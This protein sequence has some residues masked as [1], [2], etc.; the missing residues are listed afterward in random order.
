MKKQH[1]IYADVET[2][3]GEVITALVPEYLRS[4][5]L[6]E[7]SVVI[8]R[9][10]RFQLATVVSTSIVRKHTVRATVCDRWKRTRFERWSQATETAK[11]AETAM[12][13]RLQRTERDSVWK[14]A[15]ESDPV[16]AELYEQYGEAAL[17][18]AD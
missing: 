13:K 8:C 6:A 17:A 3:E 5:L 16:M 7:D 1:C 18:L 12:E 14:T 10:G 4:K 2:V 11:F 9:H 15:A